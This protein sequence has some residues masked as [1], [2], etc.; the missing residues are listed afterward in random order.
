[1]AYDQGGQRWRGETR[2]SKVTRRIR[3]SVE[4]SW[5]VDRLRLGNS[6]NINTSTKVLL[7]HSGRTLGEGNRPRG[8]RQAQLVRNNP[9]KTLL[10]I[11]LCQWMDYPG[12][13]PTDARRAFLKEEIY[14]NTLLHPDWAACRDVCGYLRSFCCLWTV[15]YPYLK[16][17]DTVTM[18]SRYITIG[19][20][21]VIEESSAHHVFINWMMQQWPADGLM[22]YVNHG[23]HSVCAPGSHLIHAT[24][25][26]CKNERI[27]VMACLLGIE[28]IKGRKL[29][30][31]GRPGRPEGDNM[32]TTRKV[33]P[34]QV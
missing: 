22:D 2:R 7:E 21:K 26:V 1:M 19:Q 17:R 11:R 3:L 31:R 13:S 15:P 16:N 29:M 10:H 8:F 5:L 28:G 33:V 14:S 27:G 23:E 20:I 25:E 18:K 12:E 9:H 6:L 24:A 30:G 32:N 34:G 4:T